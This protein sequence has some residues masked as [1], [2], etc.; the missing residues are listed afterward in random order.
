MTDE[1]KLNWLR[2]IFRNNLPLQNEMT[3]YVFVCVLDIFMTYVLLYMLRGQGGAIATESNPVA[4]YFYVNWGFNGIIY[5]K[6][7]MVAFVCVLA[8]IIA[9]YRMT[10]AKLLL[11]AGK[12]IVGGVVIYS[13]SLLV[14]NL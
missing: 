12:L 7:G 3:L 13:I 4:R 8:Q 11:N 1:P 10:T 6:M 2:I 9:Q 5:F 14:R